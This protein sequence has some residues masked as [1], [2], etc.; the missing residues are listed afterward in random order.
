MARINTDED[1]KSHNLR[2]E[3]DSALRTRAQPLVARGGLGQRLLKGEELIRDAVALVDRPLHNVDHAVA[4][5]AALAV[6]L[7]PASGWWVVGGHM[8]RENAEVKQIKIETM[9]CLKHFCVQN[10]VKRGP[11][12]GDKCEEKRGSKFREVEKIV[13]STCFVK[14][15]KQIS[16]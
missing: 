13:L 10:T 6:E 11:D 3:F 1:S 12:G 8:R 7:V 2:H 4:R 15:D 9:V 14:H 5:E 16:L